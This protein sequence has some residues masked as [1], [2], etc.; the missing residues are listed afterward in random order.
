MGFSVGPL[1]IDNCSLIPLSQLQCFC[2]LDY[3]T[4]KIATEAIS[5]CFSLQVR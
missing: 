1:V 2:N 5:P 4:K 3:T